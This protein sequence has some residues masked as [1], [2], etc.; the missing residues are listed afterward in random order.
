MDVRRGR[1]P[2]LPS[3]SGIEG[4]YEVPSFQ[5]GQRVSHPTF[6]MGVVLQCEGHGERARVRVEFPSG[7]K[8][9]MLDIAHI[10]PAA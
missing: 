6:G 9:L 5:A 2:G 3:P 10:Q 7:R 8:W 1:Q 4:S